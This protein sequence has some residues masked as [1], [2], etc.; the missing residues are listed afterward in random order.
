MKQVVE[1]VEVVVPA[2]SNRISEEDYCG[3]RCTPVPQLNN[4]IT[5]NGTLPDA[6]ENGPITL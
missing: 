5:K 3:S 2:V 6:L 1:V 4:S